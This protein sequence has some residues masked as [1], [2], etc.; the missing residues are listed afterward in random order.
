MCTS[1]CCCTRPALLSYIFTW[2][3]TDA[4]FRFGNP[5]GRVIG[6]W[7]NLWR[8]GPSDSQIRLFPVGFCKLGQHEQPHRFLRSE[9]KNQMLEI[10]SH[11]IRPKS[12]MLHNVKCTWTVKR[13]VVCVYT[14]AKGMDLNSATSVM[15]KPSTVVSFGCT[16]INTPG[17]T[18]PARGSPQIH[19]PVV[20]KGLSPHHGCSSLLRSS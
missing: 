3:T 11:S 15:S 14:P 4:V 8:H 6:F 9:I 12:S 1:Y 18:P 20:G 13:A 5:M 19:N 17:C 16:T 2:L 10:R 7:A